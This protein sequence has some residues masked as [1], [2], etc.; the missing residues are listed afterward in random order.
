MHNHA[1][2]TF[3]M[4]NNSYLPG[5]LLLGY[6]LRK[7]KVTVDLV[8]MIT[9]HITGAASNIIIIKKCRKEK[10]EDNNFF[11]ICKSWNFSN[12]F[13][14]SDLLDFPEVYAVRLCE[15]VLNLVF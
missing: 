6:E 3:L 1:F 11:G 8:C 13:E 15:K 10:Q 14:H 7:Q 5:A 4:L 9:E 2:A 12:S